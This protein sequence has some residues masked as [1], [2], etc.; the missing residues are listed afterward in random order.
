[1]I[2]HFTIMSCEKLI[3]A[4]GNVAEIHKKRMGWI[5]KQKRD[6]LNLTELTSSYTERWVG[7]N[8][9]WEKAV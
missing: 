4:A 9:R 3:I 8:V 1:M 2:E 5:K 7:G 6:T